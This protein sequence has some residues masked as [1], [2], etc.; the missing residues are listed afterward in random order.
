MSVKSA[1]NMYWKTRE[2]RQHEMNLKESAQHDK[3]LEQI[4]KT[5]QASIQRD[6]DA[7]YG[8]YAAK[9]GISLAEAKN[10]LI[11]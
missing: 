6:I 2:A 9:E 7:F 1:S 10:E 4:Y 11:A 8:R 3:M 5:M